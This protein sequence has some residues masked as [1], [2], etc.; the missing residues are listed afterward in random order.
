MN[1][2][3]PMWLTHERSHSMR[4][5]LLCISLCSDNMSNVQEEDQNLP[6]GSRS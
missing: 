5:T 4:Q 3:M 2:R 6:S 1:M